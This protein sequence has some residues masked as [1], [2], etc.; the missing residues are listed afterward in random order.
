MNQLAGGIGK[1]LVC[2]A[3][4]MI[5]AIPALMFHRYFK[6]R[7]GGYV[8]EMEMEASACSMPGRPSRRHERGTARRH[9]AGTRRRARHGQGLTDA[10]PQRPGP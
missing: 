5:V 4:G 2:T 7:I 9:R 6:G 1:A 10:H 3:T 8:I